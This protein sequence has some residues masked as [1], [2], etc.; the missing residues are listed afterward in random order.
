MRRKVQ[1]QL[2]NQKIS[3]LRPV[4][5][6]GLCP[7]DVP[8]K[9]SGHRNMPEF[10]SR[11]IISHRLSRPIVPLNDGRCQRTSRLPHISGLRLPLDRCGATTLQGRKAC[12]GLGRIAVCAR[13]DNG[14]PVPFSFSMGYIPN[15]QGSG[16]DPYAARS[17]R[18]NPHICEPHPRQCSRCNRSGY[19]PLQRKLHCNH[20]SCLHRFWPSVYYTLFARVLCDSCQIAA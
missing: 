12:R 1:R 15:D 5:V 7:A 4:P 8:G 13:F 10:T 14:R 19:R 16:E 11:K 6:T 17:E 18:L 2:S 3:L 9:S 20:G